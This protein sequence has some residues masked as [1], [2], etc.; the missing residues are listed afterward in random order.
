MK[1]NE[2]KDLPKIN[3]EN[4]ENIFNV[5]Q[6]ENGMYFYN[7]LQ[8][9]NF[10]QDVPFENL[11]NSYVIKQGDSWPLISFKTLNNTGLWWVIC[12]TNNVI[13]PVKPPIP[14]EVL[15]IPIASLVREILNN[16]RTS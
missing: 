7:L 4:M 9:I 3:S 16:V 8:T 2:I 13:N 12:L 10:P 11:F 5:Y 14:G 1:H 15:K 6:D